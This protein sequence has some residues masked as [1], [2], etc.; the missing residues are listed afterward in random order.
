MTMR[1][2]AVRRRPSLLLST[3]LPSGASAQSTG[4]EDMVGAR[5]GQAESELQRRGYVNT[6]GS[7]GDDRSYT[8]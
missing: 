1:K 3:D 6:G 7:K 5:A 2:V 4:F 8:N